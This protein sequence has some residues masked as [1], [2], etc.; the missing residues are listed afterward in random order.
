MEKYFVAFLCIWVVLTVWDSLT[1]RD[2]LGNIVINIV[3]SIVIS[4]STPNVIPPPLWASALPSIIMVSKIG[5]M[6]SFFCKL[7]IMK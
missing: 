6:V 4:I 7:V 5:L 3:G 2:V 1:G